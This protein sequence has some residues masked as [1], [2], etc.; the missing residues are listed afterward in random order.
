MSFSIDPD[1]LFPIG[2]DVRRRALDIN[3]CITEQAYDILKRMHKTWD[4]ERWSKLAEL[5]NSMKTSFDEIFKFIVSTVP[6]LIETDA[7]NYAR[8]DKRTVGE[9]QHRAFSEFKNDLPE[10]SN[11]ITLSDENATNEKNLTSDLVK[12]FQHVRGELDQIEEIISTT[13]AIWKGPAA[14]DT[15]LGFATRKEKILK[16]IM[17]IETTLSS[18]IMAALEDIKRSEESAGENAKSV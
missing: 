11:K 5:W 9:P 12:I 3:V 8:G 10:G 18:C 13:I 14:T 17:K 2:D 4:G 7:E 16:N 6:Y 1:A 15:R